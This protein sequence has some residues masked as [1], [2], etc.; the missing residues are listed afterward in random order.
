MEI[1][2]TKANNGFVVSDGKDTEVIELG[3]DDIETQE[4][5][6]INVLYMIGAWAGFVKD[7]EDD[8]LIIAFDD[9]DDELTEEDVREEVD[10]D[11]GDAVEEDD[12]DW[13]DD[14]DDDDNMEEEIA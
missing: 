8:R 10:V 3:T 7:E 5:A 12:D 11:E 2:I 4:D 9:D 6:F 14:D 13:D 1:K